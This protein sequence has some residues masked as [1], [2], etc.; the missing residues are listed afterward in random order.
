MEFGMTFQKQK[1]EWNNIP[2]VTHSFIFQRSRYT[3]NHNVFTKIRSGDWFNFQFGTTFWATSSQHENHPEK[4]S[5]ECSD[6]LVNCSNDSLFFKL[7]L[8]NPRNAD[9]KSHIQLTRSENWFADYGE[10]LLWQTKMPPFVGFL[11]FVD[12]LMALGCLPVVCLTSLGRRL[13]ISARCHLH[14]GITLRPE[15]SPG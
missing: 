3:T 13:H 2:T 9:M 10:M 4:Y 11:L 7:S 6:E 1:R 14:L 5:L 15:T 8:G 12:S